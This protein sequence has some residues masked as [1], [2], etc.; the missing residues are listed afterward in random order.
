MDDQIEEKIENLKQRRDIK[1][2]KKQQS[3]QIKYLQQTLFPQPKT[4]TL[5]FYLNQFLPFSFSSYLKK[6]DMEILK[7]TN[8]FEKMNMI[9]N[10]WLM[11]IIIITIIM[12]DVIKIQ[13]VLI[14]GRKKNSS[15]SVFFSFLFFF[16]KNF[17]TEIRARKNVKEEK[18]LI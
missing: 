13:D 9:D 15:F 10:S 14:V 6:L 11:I 2:K 18:E 8:L 7:K 3:N 5:Y 16:L 17:K 12:L 1:K 4:T